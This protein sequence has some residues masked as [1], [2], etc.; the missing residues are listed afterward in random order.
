MGA[1]ALLVGVS[2]WRRRGIVEAQTPSLMQPTQ[3][4]VQ[5][6][7]MLDDSMGSPG[8]GGRRVAAAAPGTRAYVPAAAI[9]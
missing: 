8:V 4:R 2:L 7:D 6:H 5:A 3:I 1:A 9:V